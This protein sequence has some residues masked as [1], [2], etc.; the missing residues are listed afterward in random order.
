[1]AIVIGTF[2]GHPLTTKIPDDTILVGLG[3]PINRTPEFAIAPDGETMLPILKIMDS[4]QEV[5]A[6]AAIETVCPT[7]QVKQVMQGWILVS[8]PHIPNIVMQCP[9]CYTYHWVESPVM[10]KWAAENGLNMEQR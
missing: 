4:E 5:P 8:P 10:R 3:R 1:M 2:N 9:N 6:E 7:C